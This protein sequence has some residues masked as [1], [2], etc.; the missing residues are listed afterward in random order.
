MTAADA[1]LRAIA[2]SVSDG[3]VVA[4]TD[5]RIELFSSGAERMFGW[6]AGEITGRE[7]TVLMPE[8]YR[9]LHLAGMQRLQETGRGTL[10]GEGPVEVHGLRRDGTEFPI[11]LALG[12]WG[13]QGDNRLVG[14]IRDISGRREAERYRA[15]Q[16]GVAAA[17]AESSTLDEAAAGVLRALAE[18]LGWSL[19]ALWL[20]DAVEE[21]LELAA[22]WAAPDK[23][24]TEFERLSREM[25]FTPGVGLPGRTWSAG[26][27]QWIEDV[28][29]DENFPR[30][31]AAA[32]EGLHGAVGLPL[33]ADGRVIGVL[34]LFNHELRRPS[35]AS[36][37]L[38]GAM[39]D[40]AAQFLQRKR[41]EGRLAEASLRE[42]QAAEIHDHII[43]G[44]VQA[45]QALESRDTRAA[46]RALQ[47]TLRHASRIITE[48]RVP[49]A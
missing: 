19:G 43:E 31:Q 34:E 32:A 5:S 2:D 24:V 14:I 28:L 33:R 1:P 17:V 49:K 37:E 36:L 11:E 25:T 26:E 7:L 12:R 48:L 44:L 21:R 10:L 9:D 29:R 18:S 13:E 16:L 8:R 46:D 23:A 20:V 4:G 30:V 45:T 42:R 3:I 27:P 6:S 15:A 47:E 38:M 22:L 40:Q 39:T 41:A 35:A